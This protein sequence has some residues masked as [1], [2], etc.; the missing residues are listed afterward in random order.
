[1]TVT[2]YTLDSFAKTPQGGNPAGVVLAADELSTEQMRAI[3]QR[4]GFSETAFVRKSHKADYQ[5]KFF[6]PAAEVDLC[7]HATIATFSLLRKKGIIGNGTFSQETGSG[8]L[9]ITVD[10]DIV[11][12]DQ[13]LPQ[14]D[15]LVDAKLIADSL[16]ISLDD[17][18]SDLPAQIVST[19]I[20]DIMVAVKDANV[21]AA[22]RPDYDKIT[23]ISQKYNVVGMHVFCLKTRQATT[24]QCRN[25]APLF[26]INE[27]AA[28]GTSNG[29]L[30]CYLHRYGIGNE[31]PFEFIFEQGYS[32]GKPSEIL[33][34][35]TV[36]AG[37]I[38]KIQVG[39]RAIFRTEIS[40]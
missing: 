2:V 32:M 5:V 6:T 14:Y 23:K 30:A 28:T 37:V 3:A 8:V 25:F 36:E 19:G 15:E 38:R 18:Q 4:V 12:M 31:A 9:N 16:A 10:D 20:R 35:L 22:I 34:R 39:G 1:M 17:Y 33:A 11:Y 24:V 29:A 26:G 13:V 21:L 7:G 40:L 27:E